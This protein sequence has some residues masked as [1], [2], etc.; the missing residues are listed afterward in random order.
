MFEQ[1]GRNWDN[2]DSDY[3]PFSYSH[4]DDNDDVLSNSPVFSDHDMRPAI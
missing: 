1:P 2:S 3:L 4:C